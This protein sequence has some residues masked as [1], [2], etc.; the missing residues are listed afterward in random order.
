M[1]Y[2]LTYIQ[3]AKNTRN[4]TAC[5]HKNTRKNTGLSAETRMELKDF[6][7]TR[8]MGQPTPAGGPVID[9]CYSD[10]ID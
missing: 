7:L 8:R 2:A 3:K 9:G 6:P 10:V 5:W 1:P 4:N